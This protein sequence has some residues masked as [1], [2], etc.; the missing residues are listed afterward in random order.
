M[1]LEEGR[2]SPLAATRETRRAENLPLPGDA[3][4]SFLNLHLP[5]P[6]ITKSVSADS[7][8][9]GLDRSLTFS[10][11]G[12]LG[13]TLGIEIDNSGTPWTSQFDEP[14]TMP[15]TT[16]TGAVPVPSATPQ[17]DDISVGQ[18]M[19]S[20]TAGNILTGLLGELELIDKRAIGL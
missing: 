18:R 10:Y 20:A 11:P 2:L 12:S 9:V 14:S 7:I 15:A 17:P 3:S 6:S 5:Q 1:S 16:G 8:S 13:S 19:I 4:L